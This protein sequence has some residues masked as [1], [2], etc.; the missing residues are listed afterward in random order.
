MFDCEV[1]DITITT[2]IKSTTEEPDPTWIPD[3]LAD[4]DV[5]LLG[6]EALFAS[7]GVDQD[8]FFSLLDSPSTTTSAT[9]IS[10]SSEASPKPTQV[11]EAKCGFA[12]YLAFYFRFDIA[13]MKGNWVWDDEGE[14]LKSELKGCGAMTGWEWFKRDDGTRECRFNLPLIMKGGCVERALAS[15]GGPETDCIFAFGK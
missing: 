8:E 1:A 6:D 2:T 10:T 4:E 7:I 9:T 13:D 15:A 14:S 5:E 3:I 12:L 11:P